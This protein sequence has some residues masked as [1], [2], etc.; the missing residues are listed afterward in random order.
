MQKT[1]P[2]YL[3]STYNL[4]G[5]AFPEGID[6]QRYW[7]LL[8]ILYENMSDR[9]LAQVIA[10][11][12]EKDYHVVLNDVYRV[13]SMTNLSS[14]VIDSVKQKLISCDYEKWLADE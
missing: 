10:E 2:A 8:S 14:E 4:I 3:A 9:S 7:A 13:G 5:C 12:T 6:E 1:I 11:Y